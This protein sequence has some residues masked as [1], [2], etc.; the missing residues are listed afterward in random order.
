MTLRYIALAE[1]GGV[2]GELMAMILSV[3]LEILRNSVSFSREPNVL[4]YQ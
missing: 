1:A 4:D 2:V 3:P